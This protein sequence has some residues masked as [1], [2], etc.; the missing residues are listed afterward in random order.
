[1]SW[2]RFDIRRGAVGVRRQKNLSA[3]ELPNQQENRIRPANALHA[4]LIF[5]TPQID[6]NP[7][8]AARPEMPCEKS[9]SYA[10]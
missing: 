10:C 3:N 8:A 6:F 2:P 9:S 4:S 7:A 1:L 5:Y